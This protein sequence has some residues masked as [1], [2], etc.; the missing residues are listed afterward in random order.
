MLRFW[1][2]TLLLWLGFLLAACGGSE[3]APADAPT[4]GSAAATLPA[5]AAGATATGPAYTGDLR[6]GVWVRVEGSGDCLNFR[7]SHSDQSYSPIN[8][9]QADGFEGYIVDGPVYEDG[10]WWWAIAG[11]GW[12]TEDFLRF[13]REEDLSTRVVAELGGLGHIAFVGSDGDIWLMDADGSDRR[14]LVDVPSRSTPEGQ[15]GVGHLAWRPDG[16]ALLYNSYSFSPGEGEKYSIH[17]VDHDGRLL[18]E[19]A[20]GTSGYW[21]PDGQRLSYL[22]HVVGTGC[23]L[24]TA[25]P[26][27]LDLVSGSEIAIGQELAYAEAGKWRAGGE[28]LVLRS[29]AGVQLLEADGS[30]SQ[31]IATE[32]ECKGSA[33]NWAPDGERLS[34]RSHAEDCVGYLVYRLQTHERELCAPQPLPGERGGRHG[35]PEDGQTDWSPDGRYFAYHTEFAT[36]NGNGV[37]VVDSR[38]G[39]Q[40]QLAVTDALLVSFA[41]DS[42]HLT[43]TSY[44][45][46]GGLV[47]M[48]DAETGTVLLLAEGTEAAWAPATAGR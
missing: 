37:Y 42:R 26:V 16:G 24:T 17:V 41:P 22:R 31:T 18:R 3:E 29:E 34:L 10:R 46:G 8:F 15:S 40:A 30:G 44:G 38:T 21:S 6:P 35:S 5:A 12:A 19:I 32:P 47:W 33:P 2:P 4:A 13:F 43:F 9:C 48:G 20:D 7:V 45:T 23:G 25:T 11:Q 27:V 36:V 39:A 14:R 1:R 28:Q